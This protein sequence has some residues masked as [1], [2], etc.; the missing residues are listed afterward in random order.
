MLLPGKGGIGSS[1]PG[2]SGKCP[3]LVTG[4]LRRGA[5]GRRGDLRG[6]LDERMKE[7]LCDYNLEATE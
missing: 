6:R 4:E 3:E 1:T 5:G 7:I 2:T